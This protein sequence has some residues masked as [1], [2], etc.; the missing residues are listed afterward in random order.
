MDGGAIRPPVEEASAQPGY[1]LVAVHNLLGKNFRCLPRLRKCR[2][3]NVQKG[4]K[5]S[6]CFGFDLATFDATISIVVEL[7]EPVST[8]GF[9]CFVAQDH[10]VTVAVQRR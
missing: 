10:S 9:R 7:A 5:S 3:R 1:L 8:E 6:G 4:S 2:F